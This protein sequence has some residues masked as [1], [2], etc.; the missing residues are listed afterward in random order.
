MIRYFVTAFTVVVLAASCAWS[1]GALSAP[2][3]CGGPVQIWDRAPSA[4]I[5]DGHAVQ[6]WDRAQSVRVTDGRRVQI[7]DGV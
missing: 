2:I 6:I 4:G 7:W 5:A 3:A 1:T